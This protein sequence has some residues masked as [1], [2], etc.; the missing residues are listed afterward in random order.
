V[1]VDVVALV[2]VPSR[3]VTAIGPVVAPAGTVA[4]ILCALSIVN[5]ADVPLKL[6]LVTSGPLKLVPWIVTEVPTGPPAGENEL[7][8]GAAAKAASAPGRATRIPIS[9][10]VAD[11][12]PGRR[13][14]G[15]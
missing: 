15:S 14:A 12:S 3:L 11:I 8:V 1:P 6:T 5:V 10:N 9:T 4:L 2:A 13:L 7:I